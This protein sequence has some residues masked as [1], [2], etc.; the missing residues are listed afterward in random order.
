MR[1]SISDPLQNIKF[2]RE[3]WGKKEAW[4][5]KDQYGYR[6]AGG[7]QQT[8]GGIA[9]FTDTFLKPHT[10]GR[11]DHS[12]LELS[13]GGGQFTAELIR[14]AARIDLIDMNDACLDICRERFKFYPVQMR[15]FLNDGRRGDVL[16]RSDYSLIACY[17]SMVHMHPEIIA[18]YVAQLSNRLS[19]NGILWL[20]H[21]GKGAR[22]ADIGLI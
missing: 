13:P 10:D 16:D 1:E 17:D 4:A 18:G 3:R 12:I 20:D 14:Y 19:P 8:V 21:S 9:K 5:D 22:E 7:V 6:W 2:N 11:Y 15:Y